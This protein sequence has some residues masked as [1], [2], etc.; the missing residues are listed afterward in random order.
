VS[1]GGIVGL[2]L[3]GYGLVFVLVSPH[4]I[5]PVADLLLP[6]HLPLTGHLHFQQA[7]FLHLS[8][9]QS[10]QDKNNLF[11]YAESIRGDSIRTVR[12]P[13]SQTLPPGRQN[14]FREVL[15]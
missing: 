9:G 10:T 12:S 1:S 3:L 6:T 4:C 15:R 5:R 11:R 7:L 8:T 13:E 14:D 2:L